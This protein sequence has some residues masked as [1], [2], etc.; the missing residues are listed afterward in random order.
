MA[1]NEPV[2]VYSSGE[3]PRKGD[4]FRLNN[5]GHY[6]E[7]FF[8]VECLDHGWLRFYGDNRPFL[9]LAAPLDCTLI[10]R[11]HEPPQELDH[12]N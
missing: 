3:V 8:I 7:N 9:D 11:K 6:A 1:S 12:D 4:H 10:R 5:P 2:V